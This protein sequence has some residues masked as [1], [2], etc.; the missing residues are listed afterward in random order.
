MRENK[1]IEKI[2]QMIHHIEVIFQNMKKL[3]GEDDF[4][5]D[6]P[7]ADACLFHL[8]QIGELAKDD[9][10]KQVNEDYPQVRWREWRGIRNIIAHGYD[11]SNFSYTLVWETLVVDIPILYDDLKKILQDLKNK[12][13]GESGDNGD[14]SIALTSG[15]NKPLQSKEFIK[16]DLCPLDDKVSNVPEYTPIQNLKSL[17]K[18]E[19][20]FSEDEIDL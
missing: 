15:E 4:E 16:Q 14:V 13:G 3:K 19:N 18:E 2:E 10:L 17:A 8:L 20:S 12:T 5:S 9:A 6:V 7:E 11:S 1:D